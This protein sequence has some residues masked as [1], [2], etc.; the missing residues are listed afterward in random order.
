MTESLNMLILLIELVDKL[1]WQAREWP[2]GHEG[3]LAR[4]VLANIA[5][6]SEKTGLSPEDVGWMESDVTSVP[7]LSAKC[8][9]WDATETHNKVHSAR[10]VLQSAVAILRA[11]AEDCKGTGNVMS[12]YYPMSTL[13]NYAE[14]WE[15]PLSEIGLEDYDP[16]ELLNKKT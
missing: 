15:I 3:D 11:S 14:I 5:T 4:E 6:K 7:R 10:N 8:K 9:T 13:K 2:D 16:D 1:C 12:A